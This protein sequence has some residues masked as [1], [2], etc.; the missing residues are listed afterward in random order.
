MV[1]GLVTARRDANELPI[2]SWREMKDEMRHRFVPRNY[3]RS[4]YDK[5]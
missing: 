1:D 2:L 4:L 3:I 5:L